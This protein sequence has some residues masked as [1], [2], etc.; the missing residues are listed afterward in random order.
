LLKTFD[1]TETWVMETLEE[2]VYFSRKYFNQV[3]VG[4]QDATRTDTGFLHRFA[5]RS[6]D[7]GVHRLRIADTVGMASPAMIM[8]MISGI[9]KA[10]PG[11]DLEFHGHNDLGMATANAVSAADAGAQSLS[12]TI[13]GLGERAGN[14]PLEE[15]A[16]ALFGLGGRSSPMRLSRLNSLSLMV[17][18]FSD[19][20][21]H[22]TKPIVGSRVFSHESGIHCA[23]LI[24][25]PSSYQLFDP[26]TVGREAPSLVLGSHSGRGIIHH[27]LNKKGIFIDKE[28]A[29]LL[30]AK[31]RQEAMAQ[32]HS[33]SPERLEAIYHSMA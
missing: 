4:A 3:S 12:V 20:T 10:V 2:L 33:L 16:T 24:K 6:R 5:A 30:L 23:G 27:V 28:T 15:V 21:I 25:N 29:D 11:I 14:A 7:L 8:K 26:E 13:N 19:Q 18:K 31:V 17:S 22:P 1:K 32:R 9:L